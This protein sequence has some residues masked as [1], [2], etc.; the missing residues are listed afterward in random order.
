[1][2][3]QSRRHTHRV[4]LRPL[5]KVTLLALVCP[6]FFE[7]GTVLLNPSR[8]L[9]VIV[10]PILLIRLLSGAYGKI[11]V[12]DKFLF[13][14]AGWMIL[15]I[16]INNTNVVVTFA[17]LNIT[18]LIGGYLVARATIRSVEDFF[19]FVRFFIGIILFLLPFAAYE[20]ATTHMFLGELID[21]IPGFHSYSSVGYPP[22]LGFNRAQVVF[23]HPI[24]FGLYCSM[25]VGLYFYGFANRVALFKRTFMTALLV[26]TCF[27]SVSS[28]P[29]LAALFQLVLL[30]Y[31][32][33]TRENEKQWKRLL[34]TTAI[35]YGVIE[36]ATNRFG[37]YAIASSLAL[38]SS[39]TYVRVAL[40]E[41]GTA[42]IMRTPLFGVGH[43][44]W[45]H[46]FWLS[47]SI[48]NFWLY[49]ALLHGIPAFIFFSGLFLYSMIRAGYG[50]FRRG[51][52]LYNIRVGWTIVLVSLSL[53]L[54]TVAVWSEL[55]SMVLFVIGA[56]G[57]LFYVT[58][59]N[60]DAGSEPSASDGRGLA[61]Y[62]RFPPQ[63]PPSAN[64]SPDD[65]GRTR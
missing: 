63:T 44:P 35:I 59:E 48:D 57:F 18:S 1:M 39:T 50:K 22:R 10:A 62:S 46:P 45:P 25:A 52:D 41:Y 42:Q 43:N 29:L 24:H 61:H 54:A 40:W 12:M 51:S 26:G 32:V 11:I 65:R 13:A 4:A 6:A 28:G 5:A 34:I 9:F 30:G 38:D 36:I 49:T 23:T 64:P 2:P 19:A 16:A 33:L 8:L 27:L 3:P 7:I 47:G 60:E 31:G 55:L 15:T 56:G 14:Y 20:S 53:T 37:L 21:S 58:E 17:G